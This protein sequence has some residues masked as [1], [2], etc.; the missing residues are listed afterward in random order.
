MWDGS[1]PV[2]SPKVFWFPF[3]VSVTLLFPFFPSEG[4][5][6]DFR[7]NNSV[8]KNHLFHGIIERQKFSSEIPYE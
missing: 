5:L 8:Y 4:N 1:R 6:L 2:V 7:K 3:L